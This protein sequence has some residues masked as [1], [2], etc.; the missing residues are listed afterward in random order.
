MT[1]DELQADLK[2]IKRELDNTSPLLEDLQEAALSKVEEAFIDGKST[3]TMQKWQEL[4]PV[5]K[6]YKKRKNLSEKK[7][8]ARNKL[9]MNIN[10]RILNDT[11]KIGT[12]VHYAAIHEYGGMAGKNHKVKIPARPYMPVDKNGK[13]G[14]SLERI[15]EKRLFAWIDKVVK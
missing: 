5:T 11:V 4:S 15:I 6:A 9:R 1:I 12:N 14:K 3:V 10:G 7:L 13:M 8:I 2:R